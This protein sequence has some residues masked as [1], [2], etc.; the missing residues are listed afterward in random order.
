VVVVCASGARATRAAGK[1]RKMGYEN[2]RVLSGG[3]RAWR[4]ANLPVEKKA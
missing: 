2:T 3:M 1:L 4:E